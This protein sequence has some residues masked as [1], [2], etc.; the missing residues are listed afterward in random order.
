MLLDQFRIIFLHL[1]IANFQH[2]VLVLQPVKCFL[3]VLDFSAQ[4]VNS[5]I[6]VFFQF[7]NA[8]DLFLQFLDFFKPV[9]V[10][11][12]QPLT[13]LLQLRALSRHLSELNLQMRFFTFQR[14][15]GGCGAFFEQF[16]VSQSSLVFFQLKHFLLNVCVC[17]GEFDLQVGNLAR[18]HLIFHGDCLDFFLLI[19][20]F[21]VIFNLF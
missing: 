3:Q 6:S 21:G 9:I 15:S 2:R 13:F 1:I 12:L 14:L 18:F 11:L 7:L 5:F 8:H 17:S 19:Q 4:F 10:E 16:K 20:D